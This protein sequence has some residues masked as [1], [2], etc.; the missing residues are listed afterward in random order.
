M[1]YSKKELADEAADATPDPVVEPSAVVDP[2]PSSSSSTEP[3]ASPP[4]PP[5]EASAKKKG[6]R[7]NGAK[8]AKPRVR[9]PPV[10]RIEPIP[11]QQESSPVQEKSVA[12][13]TPVVARNP[14]PEIEETPPPSPR[15]LYRETSRNLMALRGVIH[16]NRRSY[17][18]TTIS[19]K[20][21]S[22]PLV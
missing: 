1:H 18:E 4:P 20:L 17:M 5:V 9:R 8:D 14:E 10:V 6:G 16:A 21:A 15:T 19:Q 11:Q 2:L 22:W 12:A 3:V 13:V 7:P